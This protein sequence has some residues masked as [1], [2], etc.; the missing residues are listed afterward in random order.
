M[1]K[2]QRIG[3]GSRWK[4]LETEVKEDARKGTGQN[5]DFLTGFR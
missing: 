4:T 1:K 2:L 3:Q 5:S